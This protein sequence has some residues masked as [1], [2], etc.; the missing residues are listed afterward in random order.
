MFFRAVLN[1]SVLSAYALRLEP[2][3]NTSISASTMHNGDDIDNPAAHLK[4]NA[5]IAYS[6]RTA[7]F[8]D[9][10]ERLAV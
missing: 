7:S 5:V 3:G 10:P 9:I 8:Q 2:F 4:Y 1:L 6:K